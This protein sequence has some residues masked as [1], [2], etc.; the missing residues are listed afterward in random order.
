MDPCQ[1]HAGQWTAR[2]EQSLSLTGVNSL[3]TM[4]VH[5]WCVTLCAKTWADMFTLT[6]VVRILPMLAQDK[7]CIISKLDWLPIQ[8]ALRTGYPMAFIGDVQVRFEPRFLVCKFFYTEFQIGFKGMS[9]AKCLSSSKSISNLFNSD[10]YSRDDQANFAKWWDIH[11]VPLVTF[12][13]DMSCLA[14]LCVEVKVKSNFGA[15]RWLIFW[16]TGPEHAGTASN[17][18]QPSYCTLP[19]FHPPHTSNQGVGLG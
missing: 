7:I 3:L 2:M 6:I 1:K 5:R 9:C 8:T 19:M 10:P 15:Y 12:C 11:Y 14:T 13:T 4:M 16:L 17:P 18:A